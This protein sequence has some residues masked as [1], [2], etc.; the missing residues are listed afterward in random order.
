M[1]Y[2]ISKIGY[3][4]YSIQKD[5]SFSISDILFSISD[6]YI[7]KYLT[8]KIYVELNISYQIPYIGYKISI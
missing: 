2:K 5:V 3:L 8:N 1:L 6:I 4:N 7:N